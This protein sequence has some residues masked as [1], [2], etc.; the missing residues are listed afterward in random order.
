[1]AFNAGSVRGQLELDASD[2]LR[3]LKRAEVA[4]DKVG[5]ESRDTEKSFLSL[6]GAAKAAAGVLGAI[7]TA[8]IV[9]T[10]F[11]VLRNTIVSTTE[12]FVG[13][14]QQVR[15]FA[16]AA[17]AAGVRDVPR[18]TQSFRDFADEIQRTTAFGDDLVLSVGATLLN[19]GVQERQLEEA[20]QAVL[21]YA[22]ATGKDAQQSVVQ[23]GRTLS[24][25]SGE[26]GQ[27]LPAITQLTEAQLRQGAAFDIVNDRF[28]N[29]AQTIAL[30]LGGALD[31]AQNSFGDLQK[32]IGEVLAPAIQQAAALAAQVFNDLATQ[33]QANAPFI[34]EQFAVIA[35]GALEF[36]ATMAQAFASTIEGFESFRGFVALTGPAIA[37][38][39]AQIE[40]GLNRV[41][42][43]LSELLNAATFGAFT[44]EVERQ[45]RAL[46]ESE[47]TLDAMASIYGELLQESEQSAEAASALAEALRRG[48]QGAEQLAQGVREAGRATTG[49]AD[50]AGN[51]RGGL[52][53][54][55]GAGAAV[56]DTATLAAQ[57]IQEAELHASQLREELEGAAGA[58]ERTASA[59][60]GGGGEGGGFGGGADPFGRRAGGSLGLDLDDPFGAVAAFQTQSTLLGQTRGG[61]LFNRQQQRSSRI[62]LEQI[63]GAAV[64]AVNQ[65]IAEFSADVIRELNRLGI[66]DASQRSQI[67]NAR[68]TEAQRL[69]VL[70]SL[71]SL[72]TFAS[73]FL[74][75]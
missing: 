14:E 61:G 63:R 20:T 67:L 75:A 62:V 71:S 17:Q 12:A 26:L 5:D 28:R 64:T 23:L 10:G 46:A 11:N 49:A 21:N 41:G 16:T 19:L 44:E 30:T 60:G 40:V 27:A 42:L 8:A 68:V 73:G 59:F 38:T 25:L 50:A 57:A 47:Q 24:G 43:A 22:A 45:E 48:A 70:P 1:M 2:F 74:R 13:F 54:A 72:S 66:T 15:N 58:G 35:A 33:V 7:A 34:R 55:A 52:F 18:L 36:A 39:F 65:A 51:L 69:G 29:F 32:N 31:Q 53:G 37:G 6:S 9:R 56:A 4:L 3:A